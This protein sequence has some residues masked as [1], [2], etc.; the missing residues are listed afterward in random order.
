MRAPSAG[1][2]G[3]TSEAKR[4][5]SIIR[6]T[7]PQSL[8]R[9]LVKFATAPVCENESPLFGLAAS[10]SQ[11]NQA[12]IIIVSSDTSE[13]SA[14]DIHKIAESWNAY[15]TKTKLLL[16]N[17]ESRFN[18]RQKR[19]DFIKAYKSQLEEYG[20]SVYEYKGDCL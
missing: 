20:V 4:R 12:T 11:T 1:S 16:F 17:P 7:R 2:S 13:R 19:I 3:L 9:I 14:G 10:V 5:I 15:G 6:S 18:D 8:D